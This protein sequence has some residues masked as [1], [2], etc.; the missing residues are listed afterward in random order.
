MKIIT[1]VLLL[2]LSVP[3]SAFELATTIGQTGTTTRLETTG[4]TKVNLLR[5]ETSL[6]GSIIVSGDLSI[7]GEANIVMWAK[8]DGAY[9][10][11]KLPKLQNVRNQDGLRFEIPFHAAEKTVTELVIEVELLGKGSV[12]ISDLN[13]RNR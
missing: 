4:Y 6:Q 7:D 10:F 1:A 3:V 5:Q 11:S 2:I 9:Y 13:V 12:S 8:V